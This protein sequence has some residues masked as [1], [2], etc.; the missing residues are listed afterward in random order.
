ME[1][2]LARASKDSLRRLAIVLGHNGAGTKHE[3]ARHII[4]SVPAARHSAAWGSVG[5]GRVFLLHPSGFGACFGQVLSTPSGVGL[6]C[7]LPSVACILFAKVVAE[8]AELR[9]QH[10]RQQFTIEQMQQVIS[11]GGQ[12]GSVQKQGWKSIILSII[13]IRGAV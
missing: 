8:N 13:A 5:F 11:G 12:D 1:D 3:L 2:G 7:V 10:D 4:A 6:L 9:A